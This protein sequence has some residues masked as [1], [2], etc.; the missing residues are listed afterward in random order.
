M[1][2]PQG[3]IEIGWHVQMV[4]GR[5]GEVVAERLM[6]PNGAWYYTVACDDGQRIEVPDYELRCLQP[7]TVAEADPGSAVHGGEDPE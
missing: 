4:D 5:R 6:P 3:R 7:D 2:P 1:K